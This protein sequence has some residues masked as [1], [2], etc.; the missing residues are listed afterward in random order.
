MSQKF[1]AIKCTNCAAPLKILGGGRISTVT[2]EYCH[3]VL[4]MN[5]NYAVLSKFTKVKRPLGPFKIG[6]RG[7]IK[8]VEWIIIGWITYKTTEFS[9][10]EWNEFFLYSPTHGYAWL[11]YEEGV[12]SFSKKVR[13]FD[14]IQWQT[15]KPKSIFYHKGHYI[16]Y[17]ESYVCYIDYVEGEL[18]WIAK[19]GDKFTCWDYAGVRYQ[20]LSIEKSADEIEVY[21]TEKLNKKDIYSAFSLE[22][23]ESKP[24]KKAPI[25]NDAI[26]FDE[27]PDYIHNGI[28]WISAILGIMILLSFLI[29][30]PI[31]DNKLNYS[32]I[33][34]T[35]HITSDAFLSKITL[36]A[37]AYN[38]LSRFDMM[39]KK[40]K[41]TK[42]YFH[43]NKDEVFFA[44][45][46]IENKWK[47][48]AHSVT[49]YLK[50]DKGKYTLALK[51]SQG[52]HVKIKQVTIR[53]YYIF[54]MFIVALLLLSYIY[55]HLFSIGKILG[56]IVVVSLFSILIL[57][58]PFAYVIGIL[59]LLS[60]FFN[61]NED[62]EEEGFFNL[63][64]WKGNWKENWKGYD[65]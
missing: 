27:T 62:D 48:Y 60:P 34:Q 61:L 33:N 47:R 63:S 59:F 14:L 24:S 49:V 30:K 12:V 42:P 10:E 53:L 37:D 18:S 3:S 9:D 1:Y 38:K 35:I 44:D 19:F 58:I 41:S 8:G 15:N 17:E 23:K 5:D 28:K 11:V 51:H 57:N 50:L 39:I 56:L 31:F 45:H 52:V 32:G 43:M 20:T 65:E 4:D 16:R 6:M 55:K 36:K 22:Y 21:H 7:N 40:E 25:V 26:T 29:G 64:S 54:P 46:H 13:D 2:C